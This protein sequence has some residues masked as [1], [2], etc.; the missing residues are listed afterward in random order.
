MDWS[1]S[2]GSRLV[3]LDLGR[4]AQG[5][6]EGI[7]LDVE[8]IEAQQSRRAE[9]QMSESNVKAAGIRWRNVGW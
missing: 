1:K 9:Q 6:Q 2:E 8:H 5:H 7:L 3:D 4:G